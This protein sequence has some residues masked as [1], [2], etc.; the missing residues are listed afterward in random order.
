MPAVVKLL[1]FVMGTEALPSRLRLNESFAPPW[2]VSS[3][4]AKQPPHER[5]TSSM[6]GTSTP[7]DAPV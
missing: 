3:T 4:D 1:P 6:L 5:L 2:F 7:A